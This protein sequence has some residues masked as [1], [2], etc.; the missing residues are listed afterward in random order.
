[1][2][3]GAVPQLP[4]GVWSTLSFAY[5]LAVGECTV[6]VNGTAVSSPITI[7]SQE[8]EGALSYIALRS[9]GPESTLCVKSLAST[10]TTDEERPQSVAEKGVTDNSRRQKTDDTSSSFPS[11]IVVAT[12]AS[13]SERHAATSLQ[14][15][16]HAIAPSRGFVVRSVRTNE[17]HIAVGH[18]AA[19]DLG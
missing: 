2:F 9:L 1:M 17:P 18:G 3:A 13:E 12:N 19:L 15:T 11:L 8:N 5:D 10:P 7:G 4:P 14:A 6:A 16:L